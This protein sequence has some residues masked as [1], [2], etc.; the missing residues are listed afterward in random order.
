M[1]QLHPA[2]CWTENEIEQWDEINMW[3][4]RTE[5][6]KGFTSLQWMQC[7][8]LIPLLHLDWKTCYPKNE[9][10]VQ[11]QK[12]RNLKKW[13]TGK[14]PVKVWFP[15]YYFEDIYLQSLSHKKPKNEIWTWS[16]RCMLW[17]YVTLEE[18]IRTYSAEWK[19]HKLQDKIKIIMTNN[20]D[21]STDK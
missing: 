15:K 18:I 1:N 7:E 8:V 14:S 10:F 3:N 16:Y 5:R 2:S 12:K 11:K 9:A 13:H 19:H 21:L 6:S 17:I 4:T 20:P